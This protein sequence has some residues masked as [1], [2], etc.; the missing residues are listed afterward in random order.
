[1]G[2]LVELARR[3]RPYIEKAAQSLTDTEALQAVELY[4]E[5]A[6]GMAYAID[7]KLRRHGK[8]YRVLQGHTAMVGWEPEKAPALYTEINE[9]HAGTLEN[10]I[11]YEGNMA[12]ESGKYYIQDGVIY[13]CIRDTI[14]PVYHQLADLVGLYVEEVIEGGA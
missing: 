10:P 3:L 14:N 7:L 2:S 11:P 13:R 9:T 1:M 4:P 5:W 8:L 6:V 12:L